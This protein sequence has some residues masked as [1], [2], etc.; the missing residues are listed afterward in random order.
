MNRS[1]LTAARPRDT[2]ILIFPKQL[3]L[4]LRFTLCGGLGCRHSRK[5]ASRLSALRNEK[6]GAHGGLIAHRRLDKSGGGATGFTTSAPA[7][8]CKP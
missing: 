6:H 3:D 4:F 1:L 2:R 8:T 7:K 5:R